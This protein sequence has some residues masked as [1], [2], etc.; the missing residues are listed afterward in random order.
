MEPLLSPE[1]GDS[2]AG[3]L[4]NLILSPVACGDALNAAGNLERDMSSLRRGHLAAAPMPPASA[5]GL[6]VVPRT[7]LGAWSLLCF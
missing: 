3:P 1:P 5:V 2:R 4:K 7:C 6:A